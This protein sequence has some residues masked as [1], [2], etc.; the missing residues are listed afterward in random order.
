MTGPS[1]YEFHRGLE[2][3]RDFV[4]GEWQA[5][6]AFGGGFVAVYVLAI[7]AADP[8]YFYPRLITDSLNYYLTG[9][10]FA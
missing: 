1:W 2:S 7:L 3:P 9:L 4:R 6:A 5:L 8:S 10:A